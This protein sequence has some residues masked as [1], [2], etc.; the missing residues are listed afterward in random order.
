MPEP[1]FWGQ[2]SRSP[3]PGYNGNFSD[4]ASGGKKRAC[5]NIPTDGACPHRPIVPKWW[6]V[7][8]Q[9]PGIPDGW[10]LSF[11]ASRKGLEQIKEIRENGETYSV[12][13]RALDSWM[14]T[15][16]PRRC[17]SAWGRDWTLGCRR[18]LPRRLEGSETQIPNLPRRVS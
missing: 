7:Q 12:F 8:H 5:S 16:I 14:F 4:L 18:L 2:I 9:R 15:Q 13:L 17:F 1:D 3:R 11:P 10:G 6:A